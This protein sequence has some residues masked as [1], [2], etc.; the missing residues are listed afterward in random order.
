[1]YSGLRPVGALLLAGLLA[2][3][4]FTPLYGGDDD[5]ISV[6]DS[7]DTV[8]IANIPER[9]GQML[10][11]ALESQLHAAGAP[12]RQLYSLAVNYSIS[13][14]GIG[15]QGDTSVTRN[16]FTAS[17]SWTLSPI[18]T[19]SVKLAEGHASTE[20]AQNVIDQQYFALTLETDTVNQELAD[21]I[22][23]QIDTELAAYFK[24]HTGA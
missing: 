5:S 12:T 7:L 11:E 1:M 22:A 6:A 20:D 19:P 15:I 2:G 16:R 24:T 4:G 14:E 8:E 21:E 13:S 17:A 23:Q 18:G 10:R 3:C 9:P